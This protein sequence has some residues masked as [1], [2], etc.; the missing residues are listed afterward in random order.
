M[1]AII[2]FLGAFLISYAGTYVLLRFR[3]TRGFVDVPNER[4]SHEEPKPR[5]GGIAIVAATMIAFAAGS[6]LAP[7]IR[8][9]L[10]LLVGGLLLFAVGLLDDWR[11]LG[12]GVRFGAQLAAALITV[13]FGN[14]LEHIVLPVVGDINLGWAAAPVTCVFVIA[15]VNFYNF[16]DGIDGLAGGGGFI[17]S[18]FIALIAMIIGQPAL[19][20]AYLVIAGASVGFL[21]FNFP[22]SRLFMGD[23]GSTFL[24]FAFAYLA[25][26]GNGMTPHLPIFIPILILSS[27][28]ADAA[29]TLTNRLLRGE[30]IFQPHHMHYYQR[31]LSLGLNHKQVTVLE[32]MLTTLLGVSAVIYVK[33]GGFFAVFLGASWLLIF[34]ALILKIRGL[35]RGDRLFWERR[36][37]F[38]IA[39]DVAL[40]AV[41]YVGA[42][43]IRMN[44]RFTEV[45]GAAMLRALPIV[46]VVRSACFFKYGLYRS[47]WKY[48]SVPDIVRVIKAVTAG[49]IIMLTAVFILY[50]FIAFPRSL[51]VIEYFL[52]I[53]LIL[54]A[55]FSRRLFHEIGKEAHGENVRRYGI[56]G[57]GDFGERLGRELHNR[58]RV[59]VACFV[60]D[61]EGKIGLLLHGAP[62][63]GPTA[64][65]AAICRDHRLNALLIGIKNLD[66]TA[67]ESINLAAAGVGVEV[68][69][70]ETVS[71][72]PADAAAAVPVPLS[73]R[74]AG[75]YEGLR[76]VVTHGGDRIGGAL[77]RELR[78]CGAAVTVQFD[79]AA[80][81]RSV[82]READE[83]AVTAM[84][85]PLVAEDVVEACSPDVIFHCVALDA[86]PA[87]NVES[88]LWD[89]IVRE[90]DHLS[91]AAPGVR[92]VFVAFWGHTD[93]G[94]VAANTLAVAEARL[95]NLRPQPACVLRLPELLISA[96]VP[97]E[98]LPTIAGAVRNMLELGAA[99]PSGIFAPRDAPVVF[100]SERFQEP[101]LPG[102][103]RVSGPLSPA[104][105][106]FRKVIAGASID[107]TVESRGEWMRVISGQ[108][109]QLI[110]YGETDR[111]KLPK[112]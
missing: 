21:Q 19:G 104:N 97:G 63:V 30:R 34:A 47:V 101:E 65:I 53:T 37:F 71:V 26:A 27:M 45:E 38:V 6:F 89:H 15:S 28:Y 40:I 93:A 48:T 32:Y 10:P 77:L 82:L 31:L 8:E 70:R 4:S 95:L 16:I 13:A 105:D 61:D 39:T 23:G 83:L 44:F 86:A 80:E 72:M 85:G 51:F 58:P 60:D 57:A 33:A 75:F 18:I 107:S 9:F 22:P 69:F 11:G 100:P 81:H 67:L 42:Y 56:V 35:E 24:G 62:I 50:R 49:S 74:A 68:E 110:P 112:E 84:I 7:A 102:L 20:M 98:P 14:T 92:I 87:A 64:H 36:T 94:A 25:I 46:L 76:V 5:N 96:P 17:A 43:F 52:L 54:G 3:P 1:T 12:V 2:L 55:R 108:L 41:A 66:A 59:V 111:I 106:V 29:L 109:Y 73:P 88:F 103:A 90:T 91:S 99:M 78:R 79:T